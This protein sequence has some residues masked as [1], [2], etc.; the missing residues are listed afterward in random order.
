MRFH[1]S[2]KILTMF[3]QI[4]LPDPKQTG[5]SGF[6]PLHRLQ[7]SICS[8]IMALVAPC[9]RMSSPRNCFGFLALNMVEKVF[10]ALKNVWN[11][12][13]GFIV[14]GFGGGVGCYLPGEFFRVIE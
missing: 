3:S 5:H 8:R 11:G 13:I 7:V 6:L 2:G 4:T 14:I 9:F 12:I 10:N 1:S